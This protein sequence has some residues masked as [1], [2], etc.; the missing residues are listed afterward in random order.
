MQPA[1]KR[2]VRPGEKLVRRPFQREPPPPHRSQK[3]RPGDAPKA[4]STEIQ[5][6]EWTPGKSSY[7]LTWLSMWTQLDPFPK[8]A[9]GWMEEET[10][11]FFHLCCISISLALNWL[12]C[13]MAKHLQLECIRLIKE[14]LSSK[15]WE[16]RHLLR[17]DS[18][19]NGCLDFPG[20][21]YGSCQSMLGLGNQPA[22]D[23][24]IE[25]ILSINID[26]NK[27]D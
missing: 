24:I 5:G 25:L 15:R 6:S 13:Q 1:G 12:V 17:S 27:G 21:V 3:S 8:W 11:H 10:I 14:R 16:V 22:G 18:S 19:E 20:S 9:Y 23:H 2:S 4:A 26:N 7:V